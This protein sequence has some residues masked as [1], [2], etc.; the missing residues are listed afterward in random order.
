MLPSANVGG[1]T[2]VVG[3]FCAPAPVSAAFA[4]AL[5]EAVR[6]AFA[7]SSAAAASFAAASFAA[8]GSAS[9]PALRASAVAALDASAC[10]PRFRWV[11]VSAAGAPVG[12]GAASPA[13]RMRAS[14]VLRTTKSV[15]SA[16]G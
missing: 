6:S 16:S 4:A 7:L 1:C 8:A 14:V 15:R 11:S 12:A 13:A 3:R 9:C 5:A 2:P 10:R